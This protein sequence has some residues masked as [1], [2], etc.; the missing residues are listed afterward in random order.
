MC[1]ESL[2]A[3]LWRL[4]P[5]YT[6]CGDRLTEMPG[7]ARER[8]SGGPMPGM[9]FN[10]AAADTRSAILGTLAAWGGLLVEERRI[11]APR[12]SV[13][14]LVATIDRHLDWLAAHPA[15]GDLSRELA[16]VVRRA[17]RTAGPDEV[18]RIAVGP[19]VENG[20]PGALTAFVPR[21]SARA[22]TA[23]IRCDA[24]PDHRWPDERWVEMSVPAADPAPAT[25][26]AGA[27]ADWLTPADIEYR[28]SV[29]RGSVY[30]LAS[31]H[32]WQRRKKA[33]RT[34]YDAADVRHSL[35]RRTARVR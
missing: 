15:A 24:D 11:R 16:A 29:S 35:N 10:T 9:P 12:R 5:L 33:G 14:A 7:N 34:Y 1:R 23:E 17:R 2:T 32:G 31:E 3:D 6:E 30:R 18:R 27:P 8:T 13:P 21:D 26:P 25:D 20:C 22:G 28:W 4:D 19:C